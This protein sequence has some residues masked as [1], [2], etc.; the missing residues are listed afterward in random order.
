MFKTDKN[1]LQCFHALLMRVRRG[2]KSVKVTR[3]V[4]DEMGLHVLKTGDTAARALC[5]RGGN[6][7]EQLRRVR[8]RP[9]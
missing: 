4:L 1:A 3:E 7:P 5:G 2:K 6:R 8:R 9:C